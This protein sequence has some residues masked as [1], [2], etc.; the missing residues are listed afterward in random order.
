MLLQSASECKQ[1]IILCVHKKNGLNSFY[2]HYLFNWIILID[3]GSSS[4]LSL[5]IKTWEDD[6]WLIFD[7]DHAMVYSTVCTVHST[8]CNVAASVASSATC[9]IWY[10]IQ[11]I[12]YTVVLVTA[13]TDNTH[14]GEIVPGG[15]HET[16]NIELVCYHYLTLHHIASC[17]SESFKKSNWKIA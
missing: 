6:R 1:A 17:M 15:E 3:K 12:L 11:Y 10:T 13:A 8:G 4:M 7:S 16:I 9:T 14:D 5:L 2:C